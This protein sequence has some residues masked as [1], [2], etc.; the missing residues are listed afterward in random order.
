MQ[1]SSIAF[2]LLLGA[3]LA[4]AC[5]SQ[6][7]NYCADDMRLDRAKSTPGK[8]MWC[9][10]T[11]GKTAQFV[12]LHQDGKTK[13]QSCMYLE[14]K[15][16][17]S[18]TAWHPNGNTWIAGQ[19]SLGRAVGHWTQWD[20]AQVKVAEGDYRDGRFIAGAPVASAAACERQ[21]P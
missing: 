19:F 5:Q 20:K 7:S 1:R 9:R 6:K 3:N 8:A 17:G 14:G 21:T 18:F 13:R 15:A 4:L 10:S 12:E 11:D 2:A 16:E